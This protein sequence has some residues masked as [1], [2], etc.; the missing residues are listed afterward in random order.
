MSHLVSEDCDLRVKARLKQKAL[1]Y[2]YMV[3]ALSM[4]QNQHAA[5]FLLEG[6]CEVWC[7]WQGESKA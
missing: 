6:H 5:Q 2:A 3:Q 1:L 7:C 4:L